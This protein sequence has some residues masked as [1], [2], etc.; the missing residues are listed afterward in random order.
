MARESPSPSPPSLPP[1][2]INNNEVYSHIYSNTA[3]TLKGF[4]PRTLL[5]ITCPL[6]PQPHNTGCVCTTARPEDGWG[7]THAHVCACV[8][9]RAGARQAPLACCAPVFA[10]RLPCAFQGT[11]RLWQPG[12]GASRGQGVFCSTHAFIYSCGFNAEKDRAFDVCVRARVLCGYFA[13]A[14]CSLHGC[15]C[16]FAHACERARV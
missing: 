12:A 7:R 10:L 3:V 8:C 15:V 16:V 5:G 1:P 4:H 2:Y 11:C 13:H 6:P 14:V 9:A